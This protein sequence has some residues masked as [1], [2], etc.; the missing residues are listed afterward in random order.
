MLASV[1][2][3]GQVVALGM[4]PVLVGGPVDRVGHPLP[5]VGEAAAPD[6]VACLRLAA[7]VGDAF[8]LSLDPV[9]G[10]VPEQNGY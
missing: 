4:V 3:V 10:V 6:V 8:L 9:R 5:L 7:W 1:T 2:E